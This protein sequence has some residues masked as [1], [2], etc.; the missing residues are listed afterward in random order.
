MAGRIPEHFIQ[1]LLA[2]SD[3]VALI[4]SRVPL[5]KTGR[6]YAACC[7]FHQEKTPSFTVAPD[8]QFY[9]CFGCGASGNAVG[10]LMEYDHL[11]FPEA[12]EQLAEIVPL[13]FLRRLHMNLGGLDVLKRC[14]SEWRP[15]FVR[16]IDW[17]KKR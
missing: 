14:T 1:D 11:N 8:K 9:Y 17:R 15:L 3:I 12:V 4:D 16:R 10:F 5:K 2:R 7:P 6:N 13:S